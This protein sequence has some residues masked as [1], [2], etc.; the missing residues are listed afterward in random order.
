M[1]V[2]VRVRKR[3]RANAN[4]NAKEAHHKNTIQACEAEG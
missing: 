3:L 1:R 4:V 2:G